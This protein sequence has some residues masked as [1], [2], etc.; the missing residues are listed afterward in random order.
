VS[1][2][3]IQQ[4]DIGFTSHQGLTKD[5]NEDNYCAEF[6]RSSS[7]SNMSVIAVADGFGGFSL[8]EIASKITINQ[9][10]KFYKLGEFKQMFDDAEFIEPEK[11][12]QQLYTR[13]NHVVR[14]LIEKENQ[15][16]GCSLVSGFF[17]DDKAY[18]ASVGN[19]RAYLIRNGA[20]KRI[21]ETPSTSGPDLSPG[22]HKGSDDKLFAESK[23]KIMQNCLG[24]N[25]ALRAD[26]ESIDMQNGDIVLFCSD[27]VFNQV[28]E[29][30]IL[31]LSREYPSMQGLCNAI[32]EQ[33]NL[34]GGKDNSTVV[35][36]R[37][38]STKPTF[39]TIIDGWKK[40]GAL[41]PKGLILGILIIS[42]LIISII[43]IANQFFEN[44]ANYRTSPGGPGV[45]LPPGHTNV[46]NSLTL[47]S[48][49]PLEGVLI[50]GEKKEVIDNTDVFVFEKITNEIRILPD[51]QKIG[52]NFYEVTI[53]GYARNVTVVQAAYNRVVLEPGTVKVNLTFGSKINY[54]TT[55]DGETD[56]FHLTIDHLGSP[57]IILMETQENA[58][59]SLE[60]E[61]KRLSAPKNTSSGKT[62]EIL[63]SPKPTGG[64]G[65]VETTKPGAK[66]SETLDY[67][68]Q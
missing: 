40:S 45:N 12:I 23:L 26:V 32:V 65:M 14:T 34:K 5:I 10:E 42:I 51:F 53:S 50:N 61:D 11:V 18:I 64:S 57:L 30:E 9:V 63:Q 52:A 36:L 3:A 49:I 37:F 16:I 31:L 15:N 2:D 17:Y 35:A 68:L 55:K 19:S 21:I 46:Y 33:A 54:R 44:P 39:Q 22:A 48:E 28:R 66:K 27:G 67:E 62:P 59:V 24:S 56:V 47:L 58:A 8:G 43:L 41:T 29:D 25:V 20:I 1:N 7:N 60:F 4:Y 6:F 13:I 38:I